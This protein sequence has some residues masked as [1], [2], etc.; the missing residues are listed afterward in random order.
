LNFPV[1]FADG[2]FGESPALAGLLQDRRVMIVADLNAVQRTEGL[3]VSIGRYF[4]D[5][6][7]SMVGKPVLLGGGEKMKMF[8]GSGVR[9]ILSAGLAAGLRP[10]DAILAIGGG[11]L[12]DVAGFAAAQIHGGVPVI[13]IPT[14]PAAMM[15]GAFAETAALNVPE[16]KDALSLS[17]APHAVVIDTAFARTVLDGVW[18]TGFAEAVRLGADRDATL[19]KRLG[20]LSAAYAARDAAALKET[21]SQTVAARLKKGASAL[22]LAT[23]ASLE[24]K[25]GWKLPHG[26]AVAIGAVIDLFAA[27]KAGEARE[28]TLTLAYDLLKTCGIREAVYHSSRILPPELADFW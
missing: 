22:G 28:E 15:D 11:A 24:V 3:G 20:G 18:R 4:G 16:E 12:F 23:A 10:A 27:V 7:V 6:G 21:V 9:Q 13:R 26:Y 2:V 25:S 1:E 8:E 5:H 17:A 14:T 19:L